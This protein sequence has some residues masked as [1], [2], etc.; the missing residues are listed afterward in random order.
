MSR[1]PRD[2]AQRDREAAAIFARR[3]A[4]CGR[5]AH[6]LSRRPRR[7]TARPLAHTCGAATKSARCYARSGVPVTEFRA[8]IIVGSGSVSFEMMRYLTERLPVMI[9]P[10]WVSTRCQ[11]IAVATFSPI[12]S[13]RSN[14]AT[15]I[16]RLRDR[17]HRRAY[18]SRYDAALRARSAAC[19]GCIIVVPL[20]TPRLSSY[21]VHFVTP[22]PAR[23]RA[24]SSTGLR[25]EVIVRDDR[26]RRDF[27]DD[28]ADGLRRGRRAR[29]RPLP[30]R[31]PGDDVVR[32]V[33]RDA[34]CPA[35]F[36]ASTQGM[37]IDRRERETTA[38][39]A[40]RSSAFSRAWAASAGGC[41]PTGCGSCAACSTASSAASARAAGAARPTICAWA[42]RSISGASRR[43]EPASSCACAPR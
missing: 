34:R 18:V 22:I 3:R 36:P 1:S 35:T 43:T 31:R 28:R 8:A 30:S 2:F 39:A 42:T 11:P 19:A 12:S 6:R 24:R 15:A 9:A 25:N 21:W 26:A 10:R 32:R 38:V 27:P 20:F 7:R 40:Q 13:Q 5:Q 33:R 41:T 23:S 37:L 16:D 29:A 14:A 17:R 4:Q